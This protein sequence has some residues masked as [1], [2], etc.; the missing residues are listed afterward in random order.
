MNRTHLKQSLAELLHWSVVPPARP[1]AVLT[2]H[3]VGGGAAASMSVEL[4]RAQ[5]EHVAKHCSPLDWQQRTAA[6]DS[7]SLVTFDDGYADNY[8]LAAAV[9]RD[10]GI[11]AIFFVTTAFIE[12]KRDI[13]Q[14]F[15]SYGG[16]RAMSWWQIEKLC[17]AGHTIGLHGHSHGDFGRMTVAEAEDEMA[18]SYELVRSRI[19]ICAETFAYPFGQFQHRRADLLD[20][21]ARLGV[22]HVFSTD[23]K[24]ADLE[25]ITTPPTPVVVPRL[26]IDADDSVALLAGKISGNW[27]YVERVQRIKACLALRSFSPLT[28]AHR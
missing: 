24:R 19:G 28:S 14:A 23:H 5:M 3:S 2:Y 11:R 27:D 21:C 13:T 9:L 1:L 17:A 22:G 15:R 12:G 6:G 10:V 7:A 26:R 4:F 8:E 25:V 20:C 18:R 16:L